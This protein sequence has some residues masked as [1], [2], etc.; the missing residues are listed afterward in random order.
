MTR[1]RGRIDPD[2]ALVETLARRR[3]V[4]GELVEALKPKWALL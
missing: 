4:Y 1:V 2:P 3:A